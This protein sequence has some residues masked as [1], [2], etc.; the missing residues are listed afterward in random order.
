M[1]MIRW[2]GLI[3]FVVIV[4]LIAVFNI[5]FLD[6]IVERTVEKQASLAVGARVDIGDLDLSLL[7]LSVNI[8]ELEV[9]NPDQPM[10][11]TVEV[12]RLSFDLTALPLLKKKFVI[13]HMAVT[14]L[15]WNTPRRTSG[16]LPK[17]VLKRQ[18]KIEKV[19]EAPA[20]AEKRLEDCVLPDLSILQTLKGGVPEDLLAKI[21]LPSTEFMASYRERLSQSS[22]SWDQ[23]LDG[24][25]TAK[26]IQSLVAELQGLA[27]ERPKDVSKLPTYLNEIKALQEKLSSEA[28]WA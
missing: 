19:A 17:R 23:R 3:A 25:P 18:R 22:S 2:S 12:G 9:A 13:R 20:A 4:G 26:E 8:E 24:L 27:D 1:K 11:N 16:A 15:A 21:S 6:G 7:G 28:H 10:R 14:G 5:F